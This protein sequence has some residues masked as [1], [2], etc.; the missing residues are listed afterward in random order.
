VCCFKTV[1]GVIWFIWY[2]KPLLICLFQTFSLV[3]FLEGYWAKNSR[4]VIKF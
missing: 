2:S 4:R 3:M 1:P